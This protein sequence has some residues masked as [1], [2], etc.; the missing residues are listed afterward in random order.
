MKSAS[1]LHESMS[2]TTVR[3]LAVFLCSSASTLAYR[4]FQNN[5]PSGD[6]VRH[7]CY[8][9]DDDDDELNEQWQGVGHTSSFGG[10]SLNVFGRQF[11]AEGYMWTKALC[12]EDSDGD[13]RSNGVEL[14]DPL[15]TWPLNVNFS[16]VVLATHPGYKDPVERFPYNASDE[17]T[18]DCARLRAAAR[19]CGIVQRS[20]VRHFDVQ[21]PRRLAVS[22]KRETTYTCYNVRVPADRKFHVVAWGPIL[23]NIDVV[24]HVSLYG[25]SWSVAESDPYE[26]PMTPLKCTRLIAA[27]TFAMGN[28]TFCQLSGFNAAYPFGAGVFEWAVLRVHWRNRFRLSDQ[29]DA[30][31]LRIYYT[32]NVRPWDLGTLVVGQRVLK[33]PPRQSEVTVS[34]KCRLVD[35]MSSFLNGNSIHVFLAVNHMHV[36]GR[37][38]ETVVY[39]GSDTK[40]LSPIVIARD[41][42]FNY[43]DPNFHGLFT[44]PVTVYPGDSIEVTCRYSS[45]DQDKTIHYGESLTEEEMCYSYLSYYPRRSA[46]QGSTVCASYG[47]FDHCDYIH[48]YEA[49]LNRY[50]DA[51]EPW[52]FVS[53]LIDTVLSSCFDAVPSIYCSKHCTALWDAIYEN[54]CMA[55]GTASRRAIEDH[56]RQNAMYQTLVQMRL[57]CASKS[58]NVSCPETSSSARTSS[59][60]GSL[61]ILGYLFTYS[62]L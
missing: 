55:C 62:V 40:R 48:L 44:Q 57:R 23:D 15:C 12:E 22:W 54:E 49:D 58:Y 33:I 59:A 53:E 7:P 32:P 30:S 5:I 21:L 9:D 42:S 56:F 16:P 6:R 8:N 34:G 31:G 61:L 19:P 13:G 17:T 14:N 43:E 46:H 27:W 41:S 18:L 29:F 60:V 2:K 10:T 26:C 38:I 50:S 36:H 52:S 47:S 51:C 37:E 35:C 28:E 20:D 39:R 3:L 24:H 4:M 25:C 1:Q 11:A 45:I